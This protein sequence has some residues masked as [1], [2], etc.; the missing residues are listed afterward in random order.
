MDPHPGERVV[1]E[2]Q[3]HEFLEPGPLG[4]LAERIKD[5][6]EAQYGAARVVFGSSNTQERST[7][8]VFVQS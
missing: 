3:L 7:F 6:F 2:F 5:A 1:A 4:D 8:R